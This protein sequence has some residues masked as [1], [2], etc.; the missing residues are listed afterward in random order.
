MPRS[1]HAK[2]KNDRT[3]TQWGLVQRRGNAVETNWGRDM[4]FLDA[5]DVQNLR[6]E[7]ESG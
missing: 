2:K 1:H 6:S 7:D 3:A 5:K 4:V